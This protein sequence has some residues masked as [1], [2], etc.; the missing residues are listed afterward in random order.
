MDKHLFTDILDSMPCQISPLR[1]K[2]VGENT[3]FFYVY[4]CDGELISVA[5][6]AE[7]HSMRF[8]LTELV[9]LEV[10]FIFESH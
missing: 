5:Y 3:E 8:T 2:F 10:G 4:M 6:F 7:W 9:D 1:G